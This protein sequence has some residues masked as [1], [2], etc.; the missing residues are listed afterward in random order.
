VKIL[1]TGMTSA[2]CNPRAHEMT[3]N[4]PGYLAH[5]LRRVGHE[6]DHR[7]PAIGDDLSSY[8]SIIVGIAP[9]G[10]LGANRAYGALDTIGRLLD[11]PRLRLLV[12]AP[13]PEKVGVSLNHMLADEEKLFKPFFSYRK[14]YALASTP[15]VRETLLTTV[16][17][18]ANDTWPRTI[19]PALP[20]SLTASIGGRLPEGAR[21][22][23]DLV[24]V[25]LWVLAASEVEVQR[26]EK[27][28]YWSYETSTWAKW[29]PRQ[30]VSWDV[31]TIPRSHRTR[32]DADAL[33]VIA[34]SRGCLIGADKQGLWWNTRFGQALAQRVPIFTDWSEAQ[35][36][37]SS[38]AVL[39]ANYEYD[40]D[41]DLA[42]MQYKD[43]VHSLPDRLDIDKTIR[44]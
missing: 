10:S 5:A 40:S 36:L 42:A 16:D 6:V 34:E 25:D 13:E 21:E 41:L 24:S 4:Y 31:V 26:R 9:L 35:Y 33:R 32:S 44:S 12:D 38:F 30:H 37:S 23:I 22:R 20:W 39:P 17:Y 18:L 7:D 29:L 2:Q 15:E 8:D 43:Y 3:G 28:D 19:V 11:D 1:L 14:Q 27:P